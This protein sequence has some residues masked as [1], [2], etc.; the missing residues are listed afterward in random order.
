[1]TEHLYLIISRE[2]LLIEEKIK[3]ITNK[4]SS[5]DYDLITYDLSFDPIEDL[6]E[7]ITTNSLFSN[8]KVIIVNEINSYKDNE[9]INNKLFINYFKKPNKDNI[10]IITSNKNLENNSLANTLNKYCYKVNVDDSSNYQ[11]K[12]IKSKIINNNFNISDDA[13]DYL[14]TLA[15]DNLNIINS[16]V[17]KLMIYKND[18]KDIKVDDIKL[19]VTESPEENVFE[20]TNLFLLG[21]IEEA[22]K[23]YQNLLATNI[24]P[25]YLLSLISNRVRQLIMLKKYKRMMS[26]DQELLKLVKL[27]NPNALYYLNQDANKVSLPKLLD[28]YEKCLKL[29]YNIKTG[30]VNSE[31]GLELLLLGGIK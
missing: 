2:R 27:N 6:V 17:E 30:L 4:I 23:V 1:M 22:V 18:E 13:L 28:T 15:S 16:E 25:L 14:F 24:G 26:N 21:Q 9:S 8:K 19:L 11:K 29:D 31:T 12:F 5:E 20:L 10:V 3:E 7:E